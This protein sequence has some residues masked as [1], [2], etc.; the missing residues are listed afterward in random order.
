MGVAER[1]A[2]APP[3]RPAP[4]APPAHFKFLAP[5][6]LVLLTVA[7]Y[8]NSFTAGFPLDN[9]GLI[10]EDAR[11][12]E[13]TAANV[14]LIF[15]HTYWWPHGESG[16]YRPVTTL[17]Y[18]LNYAVL[19]NGDR[20]AGYH[21]INLLLHIVNV[22]LAYALIRRLQDPGPAEAGHYRI[23]AF[24]AAALWAVLP[25]STEAVTNIVG[26]ADLLAA[27]AVLGG[28]LIYL[29]S[30][31]AHGAARAAWLAAL[32]AITAI[33]AFSKES[34]VATVAVIVVYEV[35]WRTSRTSMAATNQ[36]KPR[37]SQSAQRKN[38]WV[39]PAIAVAAPL[40]VMWAQ[41]AAV[42]AASPAA[43][44]P[45]VDNP[46][47]GAGFWPGRLTALTVIGRDLW[48]MIWPIRLSCDYSYAQIPIARGSID[49][50][51]AW[52]TVAA[53]MAVVGIAALARRRTL[54]F[55]AAFTAITLLPSSNLIVLSGTIMAERLLY[56][57]SLGV[58]AALV[59]GA[60]AACRTRTTTALPPLAVGIVIAGAIA[61]CTARTWA[62]NADWRNEVTLWTS[63]VRVVPD[64]YKAHEAL[65]E[66]LYDADPAHG[67]IDQVIAEADRAVAILASLPDTLTSLHAHRQAAAYYLDKANALAGERTGRGASPAGATRAYQQSLTLLQHCLAILDAQTR[68]RQD[69]STAPAADIYRLLAATSLGLDRPDEAATAAARARLLEP[70]NALGYRLQAA[71]LVGGNHEPEAAIALMVGSMVTA[72]PGLNEALVNLYRGGLDSGGCALVQT[73]GGPALNPACPLVHEQTCA[74]VPEAI[75]A[76]LQIG[77]R[78]HAQ[79]LKA[80]ALGVFGCPADPILQALPGAP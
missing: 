32:A 9:K 75:A 42:L 50:W 2:P 77:R 67:N 7:A 38:I 6:A 29:K 41:R 30:R 37:S 53:A 72:D 54:L 70:A 25:L 46:I 27:G 56:L 44:W 63:A 11:V 47:T 5:L 17:S 23:V 35:I 28:L 14:A 80:G 26:R 20:P 73:A 51:M 33:G 66:A 1:R 8:S 4:P 15:Q 69:A 64:S 55:F 45:F 18:L 19:G 78:A 60:F 16:L 34:A 58:V 13:A 3:A 62:R 57:P 49:D 52:A 79:Q 12:H 76:D 24:A 10:L 65:A 22:L 61:A 59:V 68:Q 40:L 36:K 21:A 48:L 74:A 31:D 39:G 71:A 43:E